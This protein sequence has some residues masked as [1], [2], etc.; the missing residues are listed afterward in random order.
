M[1]GGSPVLELQVLGAVAVR[2]GPT[3]VT[4]GDLG[5]RRSRVA[6]ARLA[7]AG[8]RPVTKAQLA[9]ALWDDQPPATWDTALRVV[10]GRI[11]AALGPLTPQC[12]ITTTSGGYKLVVHGSFT[13]D[14]DGALELV[15]TARTALAAGR[16]AE[17]EIGARQARA[18]LNRSFLVGVDGAWV[19]HQRARLHS[20]LVDCL[21]VL[22]EARLDL[23][24]AALAAAAATEALAVEPYRESTH[25]LL[26]RA[27]EAAGNRAE[28]LRA[29][30]RCRR[31]LAEEMG[32]DPS[33]ETE[34]AYRSLLGDE[35]TGPLRTL[36]TELALVG[37]D[38]ELAVVAAL[39][40]AA[41]TGRGGTAV[42]SGEAGSGKTRLLREVGDAAR[43]SGA[44]VVLAS[45]EES[46]WWSPLSAVAS[47]AT[48]LGVLAGPAGADDLARL[49][50][51]LRPLTG[52]GPTAA[53]TAGPE[54]RT[55]SSWWRSPSGASAC[56]R[57]AASPSS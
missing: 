52:A 14:L 25:R 47:L 34:H 31:L 8:G 41:R 50:R 3:T 7:L 43:A 55:R 17:A 13:V 5:G 56:S 10:I 38:R 21:E 6:L 23:G 46:P 18:V 54:A 30:N 24:A 1:G 32:V 57:P 29:Y 26:M 19:E 42:A 40:D 33:P 28:A 53:T 39:V 48:Q 16:A 36:P 20:G 44:R 15:D 9:D 2:D 45:C 12:D 22:T 37:R 4:E 11:R 49:Q 51:L 35:P 27:H